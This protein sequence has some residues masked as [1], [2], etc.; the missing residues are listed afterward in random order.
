MEL[1]SAIEVFRSTVLCELGDS[2]LEEGFAELQRGAE[3][4]EVERLPVARRD[5][6][7]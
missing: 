4:L 1:R 3:L 2:H 6:A 7:P 5:R